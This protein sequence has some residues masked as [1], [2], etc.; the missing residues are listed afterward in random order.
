M[1]SELEIISSSPY[2]AGLSPQEMRAVSDL[3]SRRS[4]ERNEVLLLEEEEAQ[5]MY[6]VLE[7]RVKIYK[8]SPD[9]REQ[10]L[11]IMHPGDSLN[12]VP[13]FD[14][15]PNPASAAAMGPSV[16]LGLSKRDM[17]RL[18]R[19]YP[20]VATNALKVVSSR[21]RHLVSLVEDLSLRQVIGRVAKILLE[22]E[23][24]GEEENRLTQQQMA[25]LAGTAR[26]MVSR[27]LRALEA[28]GA[29]RQER[30]RITILDRERLQKLALG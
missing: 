30:Q 2:F 28:E 5:A 3:T 19:E 7:G 27:S 25:A 15:G 14:G 17:N 24:R 22:L 8:T 21:L 18:L 9:G 23:A 12:E 16:V 11:R 6:F 26:E 13:L 1:A 4:L 20:Q 10:I 29:I